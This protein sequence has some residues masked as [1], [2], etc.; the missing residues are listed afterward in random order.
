MER[1][2]RKKIEKGVELHA[3]A[4]MLDTLMALQEKMDD[5][6][7]QNSQIKERADIIEKENATIKKSKSYRYT[8]KLKSFIDR[9]GQL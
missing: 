5:L 9:S 4:H 3:R 7:K 8:K 6:K 2:M 1:D